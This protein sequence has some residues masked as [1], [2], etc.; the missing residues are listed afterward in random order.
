MGFELERRKQKRKG[1]VDSGPF[2]FPVNHAI[3]LPIR[4]GI[5]S[6]KKGTKCRKA[7]NNAL[8]NISEMSINV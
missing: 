6:T 1:L 4:N 3:I 7:L 5:F 8:R 2:L